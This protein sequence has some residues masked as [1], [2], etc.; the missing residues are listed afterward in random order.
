MVKE[1]VERLGV[2]AELAALQI[3]PLVAH[4]AQGGR[5]AVFFNVGG[6]GERCF[7]VHVE[8]NQNVVLAND[9]AHADIVPNGKFH[10]SAVH[11]AVSGEVQKHR[12]SG[13]FGVC[14]ALFVVLEIRLHLDGVEV[15]VLRGKRRCKGAD[16]FQ[17]C[18]PKPGNH[19]DGKSQRAECHEKRR[20]GSLSVF[21]IV[22]RELDETEKIEAKQTE[23]HNPKGE[24]GL[25]V[26]QMPTVGKVSHGEELQSKCEFQK[27]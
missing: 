10:L 14:H 16:G 26:Q 21:F 23:K 12:L 15:E 7:F 20:N 5:R 11:A 1:H 22:V 2:R 18:T 9:V 6:R 17:R 25:A 24:E 27:A 8:R 13:L 4:G 3:T 19:V